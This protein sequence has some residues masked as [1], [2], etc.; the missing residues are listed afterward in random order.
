MLSLK[1][2]AAQAIPKDAAPVG[3]SHDIAAI[4]EHNKS[5][6]LT[7]KH[8]NAWTYKRN[9]VNGS[10]TYLCGCVEQWKDDKYVK[11]VVGCGVCVVAWCGCRGAYVGSGV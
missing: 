5:E 11:D 6:V 3:M 2:L 1:D 9:E 7:C 4:I 10:V 8:K